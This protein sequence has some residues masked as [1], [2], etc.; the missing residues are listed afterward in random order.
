MGACVSLNRKTP[1]SQ[2]ESNEKSISLS[3]PTCLGIMVAISL[4]LNC[5]DFDELLCK[6][7]LK[8]ETIV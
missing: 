5:F 7:I 3:V 8:I 1:S 6:I 2:F 4:S